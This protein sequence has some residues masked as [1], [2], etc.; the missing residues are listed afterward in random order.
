MDAFDAA[1]A[2]LAERFRERCTLE[3]VELRALIDAGEL[4]TPKVRHLLHGLAGTGG[5]FGFDEVSATSRKLEL[6]LE[7]RSVTPA[8]LDGLFSALATCTRTE[9]EANPAA[10]GRASK[11]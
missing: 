11:T 5:S 2:A 9:A 10:V 6:A 1:M 4:Y 3:I 7:N 8:D